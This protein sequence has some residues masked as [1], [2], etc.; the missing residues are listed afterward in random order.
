M[1]VR[2]RLASGTVSFTLTDPPPN[3]ETVT[4]ELDV[5]V[6]GYRGRIN[7]RA[8]QARKHPEQAVRGQPPNLTQLGRPYPAA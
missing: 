2:H 5:V 4:P 1:M 8:Q 7:F 3:L 6:V